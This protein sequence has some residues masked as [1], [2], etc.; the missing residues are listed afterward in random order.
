MVSPSPAVD[1]VTATGHLQDQQHLC[2]GGPSLVGNRRALFETLAA[3]DCTDDVKVS[4]RMQQQAARRP[5]TLMKTTDAAAVDSTTI[6]EEKTASDDNDS[7][8]I[9]SSDDKKE[10]SSDTKTTASVS[11]SGSRETLSDMVVVADEPKD[12]DVVTASLVAVVSDDPNKSIVVPSSPSPPPNPLSFSP[13]NPPSSPPNP[14]SF[15]PPSSELLPATTDDRT[16]DSLLGLR[17]SSPVLFPDDLKR[18]HI[19]LD[20]DDIV[21]NIPTSLPDDLKRALECPFGDDDDDAVGK[22]QAESPEDLEIKTL[23]N[24]LLKMDYYESNKEVPVP[25]PRKRIKSPVNIIDYPESLNPFDEEDD[26]KD[27]NDST[28]PFGSDIEDEEEL[29]VKKNVSLNPFS[30]DEDENE[31]MS[32]PPLP[33]PR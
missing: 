1:N 26:D 16:D 18:F 7:G 22:E 4:K 2:G 15:S 14:P 17:S 6:L 13:P 31:P 19:G 25:S 32:Q 3:A 10:S 8:V 29:V 21:K 27:K 33:R 9:V 28:N 30:S 20:V 5:V 12:E 11:A 24:K 23:A